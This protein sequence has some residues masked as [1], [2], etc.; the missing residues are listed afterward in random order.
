MGWRG[1]GDATA[2]DV[3]GNTRPLPQPGSPDW[4]GSPDWADGPTQ[5]LSHQQ[6]PQ[7]YQ[8]PQELPQEYKTTI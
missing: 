8:Q 6:G 2:D 7:P 5:P 1:P 3:P 4:Q